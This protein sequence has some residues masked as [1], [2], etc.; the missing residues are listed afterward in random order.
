MENREELLAILEKAAELGLPIPADILL[1]LAKED[2][3]GL[4]DALFYK[5][6]DRI[7]L[8]AARALADIRINDP[9]MIKQG[10]TL[11]G[12]VVLRLE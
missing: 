4:V 5:N 11:S 9:E 10:E 7:G 1:R 8:A 3:Q 6:D 2:V 12:K